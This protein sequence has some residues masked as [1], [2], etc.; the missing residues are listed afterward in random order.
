VSVRVLATGGQGGG[1]ARARNAGAQAATGEVLVFIDDDVRAGPGSLDALA[2]ALENAGAAWVPVRP[3]PQVPATVYRRLAYAGVAHGGGGRGTAWHFC[4]SLAAVRREAFDAVGGFDASFRRPAYEDVDLAARLLAAGARVA[5]ADDAGA[6]H[7]R[8]MDRAW[9]VERCETHGPA[10]RRLVA[11]QPQLRRTAHRL[12]E[13]AAALQPLP[14]LAWS[15]ARRALPVA[16][17]LPGWAGVLV[18]RGIHAAGLTASYAAAAREARGN[19][20]M[21]GHGCGE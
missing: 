11:R 10:L 2:R 8:V 19:E 15:A 1:P 16:E 14:R 21:A 7:A 3:A 18:L 20:R 13:A 4:T 5:P 6:L 17:R 9:F 12:M